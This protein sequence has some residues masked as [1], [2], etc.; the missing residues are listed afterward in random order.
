M[1]LFTLVQ[2]TVNRF[3]TQRTELKIKCFVRENDVWIFH[4]LDHRPESCATRSSQKPCGL[5]EPL[6]ES[7]RFSLER[8]RFSQVLWRR[9]NCLSNCNRD[10]R[11]SWCSLSVLLISARHAFVVATCSSCAQVLQLS[12]LKCARL[13]S[14]VVVKARESKRTHS[15]AP[16]FENTTKIQREDTQRERERKK[17]KKRNFGP[18]LRA[19]PSGRPRPSG[20]THPLGNSTRRRP[21]RDRK[22]ENEGGRGKK[23]VGNFGPPPPLRTPPFG[24]DFFWVWAPPFGAPPWHTPD[25]WI[26]QNWIGQIGQIRMAKTGLAKVGPFRTWPPNGSSRVRAKTKTSQETQRSLQKFL[27]PNKKPKVIYTDNS[28]NLAKP[29]KIFPGIIARLHHLDQKQMGLLKEQCADLKKA[30]LPHCCH[31]VWMKIGGQIPCNVI[32]TCETFKIS[33]LMGRPHMG[34]V[35]GSHLKDQSFR[36]VHWLSVTLSLRKTSQES[37]NLERKSYLDC[38]LLCTRGEFGRVTNWLQT[39]RSWKRRTHQ[40][41]TQKDSL[42]KRWYFPKK[43]E[44]SFFQSQMDESNFL[45]EIKTWE[46]PPWCGHR[47][48]RGESHVD[49]LGESEGSLPPPHDS[50]PHAGE[51]I[52]DF[53]SMS[54]NFLFRHYVEPRVK[55]YSPREE[56]FP[57]CIQ[58]FAYEFGCQAR[59]THRRLLEYRWVTTGLTQPT[60][61]E[62]KPPD[63]HVWSGERLTR[64]QLTSRP[65]HLWARTLEENEKE[66]QAE[67][68]AKVVT[69]KAKTSIMPEKLRGICFIDREDTEFKEIIQKARRKLET[70]MAPAVPCKTCKKSMKGE[71][72]DKTNDFNSKFACIFEASESTRMRKEES[73][74]NFHEDHIAGKGNNSLQH[75]N[76]AHKFI[77][78]SNNEDT[79]SKSSSG[80]RMG[81]TWKDSGVGQTKS[82]KH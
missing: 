41:S 75:D 54:G 27:E 36:L 24:T 15:R 68:E 3:C 20:P 29:V 79:R 9:V 58:N 67:G 39:L 72:R 1:D 22:S 52:N 19:H 5:P 37:I 64:K 25:W 61:L 60:L 35:L 62:E 74:P 65:D 82:Q 50:F 13:G 44:N 76:L 81:K 31:Q 33:S 78:V 59:E 17:K 57:F 45:E 26:G 16:A 34:D 43:M 51:T 42:R 18:T 32:P 56:S 21:E 4:P 46:H 66:C 80:Q 12:T 53:W 8:W 63:G 77:P 30:P 70:P 6:G 73:L 40:K 2:K 10:L 49:F 55:L 23:K 28:L 47:P 14:R 38:S 71:T 48:I 11:Q 69:W 7:R